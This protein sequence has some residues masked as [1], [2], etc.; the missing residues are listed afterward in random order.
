MSAPSLAPVLRLARLAALGLILLAVAGIAGVAGCGGAS[1]DGNADP[2]RVAPKGSL[3][4]AVGTISPEGDQ[5]DA[6]NSVS[7]KLFGEND[8]GKA[9]AREVQRAI[10]RSSSRGKLDFAKDIKPWLGK[11]AAVALTRFSSSGGQA[12]AAVIVAS[13][14]VDA[15]RDAIK[16]VEQGRR[17][18]TSSH[19][20]VT[21]DLAGSGGSS[22]PAIGVVGDFLV[23]G[24]KADAFRAVVD[25][26]KDG[27]LVDAPNFQA[28]K[29]QGE[30]KLGLAYIDTKTFFGAALQGL[31]PDQR[32]AAQGALGQ[33]TSQPVTATLD[34]KEDA[35][36]F[37]VHA[38][39]ARANGA[40][41]RGGPII[42]ELPG[43]SFA[44]IGIPRLGQ[45]LTTAV[46]N[47]ETGLGSVV[48]RPLRRMLVQRTGL[49][50]D[51]DVLAALGDVA[52]FARGTSLLTVGGGAVVQSQNPAA[53]RRLVSKLGALIARE[54]A[55]DRV[56][57]T[58]TRVGGADGVK[59]TAPRLPGA[60]NFVVK[61]AKLVIA[62]SDQATV[63]ALSP[64]AKLAESM[65]YRRAAA[66]LGG[67]SPSFFVDFA[68]ILSLV[69]ASTANNTG[70][71]I[72]RAKQVLRSLDTLALG[73]RRE[74]D[75][76]LARLVVT[77]K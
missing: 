43:D 22:A 13:K 37:E 16:K 68:P 75:E 41:R 74:G 44:A 55:S 57:S 60:V 25:A 4:Y 36:S 58:R 18:T 49:D 14:D 71:S 28:A 48:I 59:I 53:A 19:R 5:R 10:D 50:L 47:L 3:V 66:S 30:G 2:A 32:S 63:E 70:S 42:A 51:R 76:Q 62:Y 72:A 17:V 6:V 64:S 29:R 12:S 52:F 8:P 61:G 73:V 67:I 9:I 21:F 31:P 65:P 54:G 45:T 24:L 40:G 56:R 1:G 46:R 11:R 69:E 20:G 35:V 34:G 15:T 38:A 77:L 26:S 33:S 23:V 39:A 27:G 7:R